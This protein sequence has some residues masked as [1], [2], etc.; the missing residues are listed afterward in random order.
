MWAGAVPGRYQQII[1][2]P[3]VGTSGQGNYSV[4]GVM[5]GTRTVQDY[6]STHCCLPVH[7]DG[8]LSL[9]SLHQP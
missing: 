7:W 1:V 6:S 8:R 4:F 9:K 3:T 2:P 5:V